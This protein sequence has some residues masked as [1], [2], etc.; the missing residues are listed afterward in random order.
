MLL[1]SFLDKS[2]YKNLS[3]QS[4]EDFLLYKNV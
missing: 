3:L 1:A 4:Q 2:D